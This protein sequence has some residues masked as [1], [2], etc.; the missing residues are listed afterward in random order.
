MNDNEATT[1]AANEPTDM[2]CMEQLS[3]LFGNRASLGLGFLQEAGEGILTHS[4]LTIRCGDLYM[5]TEPTPLQT[6]LMPA[7]V[8][9]RPEKVN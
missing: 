2:E 9:L 4:V 8:E 6:F 7:P 3:Y 5:Q 1:S